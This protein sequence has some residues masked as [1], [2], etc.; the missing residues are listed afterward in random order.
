MKSVR[1]AVLGILFF[2]SALARVAGQ[3][4][5]NKWEGEIRLLEASDRTNPPPQDAILFIGSSS[6]RLWKSLP[7]DLP[8]YRV[9]NHGFGGSEIR[10]SVFYVDR[11]VV[12]HRPKVVVMYAGGNDIHGGKM[13]ETVLADFKAFVSKLRAKLP[14]TKIA[15]ISIAP[16]PARWSEGERVKAANSLIEEFAKDNSVEFI[17]IFSLVLGENGQPRGELFGPDRL[18]M[19]EKGYAIWTG[20]LRKRFREWNLVDAETVK[21]VK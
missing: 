19:N 4:L 3:E 14:A 15:Y 21:S 9:I 5:T 20:V 8:E 1:H 11:L 10:D 6:I 7:K 18:H 2:S 17:N 12:P 13:P 16:N